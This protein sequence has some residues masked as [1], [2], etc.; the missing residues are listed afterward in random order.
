MHCKSSRVQPSGD[1]NSGA[2]SY[3]IRPC[4]L[5][6]ASNYQVIHLL[7]EEWN[8][9]VGVAAQRLRRLS[10]VDDCRIG[11]GQLVFNEKARRLGGQP[12]TWVGS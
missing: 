12:I 8:F 10:N 4:M 3:I 9:V 1:T 6:H 5:W 2:S 11:G 7:L